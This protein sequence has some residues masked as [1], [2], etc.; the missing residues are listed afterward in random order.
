MLSGTAAAL[1]PSRP[2][3][4]RGNDSPCGAAT[5]SA[6]PGDSFLARP[7]NN[8]TA[9][10]GPHRTLR[11]GRRSMDGGR[12][13]VRWPVVCRL[14]IHHHQGV[15]GRVQGLEHRLACHGDPA[16]CT[17]PRV[18]SAQS[19]LFRVP[20]LCL[21]LVRGLAFEKRVGEV[22][23]RHRVTQTEQLRH[24]LRGVLRPPDARNRHTVKAS[25]SWPR[26]PPPATPPARCARTASRA[27][28]R[29]L[30]GYLPVPAF[31]DNPTCSSSDSISVPRAPA[32]A[33]TWTSGARNSVD[34]SKSLPRLSSVRC[35]TRSPLRSEPHQSVGV[36]DLAAFGTGVF[37]CAG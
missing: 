9:A 25:G 24:L 11:P 13:R 7:R 32:P 10:G 35:R 26:S 28:C 36:V 15:G 18:S 21:G 16:G 19:L 23:Q 30:N 37:R 3:G 14:A 27:R 31:L 34:R 2:C 17:S 8:S 6:R 5:R 12:R 33:A 1:R 29:P 4:C 22:V 20:A